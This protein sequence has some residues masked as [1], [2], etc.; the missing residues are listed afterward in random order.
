MDTDEQISMATDTFLEAIQAMG[1]NK[2]AI[3]LVTEKDGVVNT[4]HTDNDLLFI[5][6]LGMLEIIKA[7][8]IH[9][10]NHGDEE[11]VE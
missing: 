8:I 9:I 2:V 1:Y 10:A 11:E 3:F 6:R 4:F 7:N 5:E